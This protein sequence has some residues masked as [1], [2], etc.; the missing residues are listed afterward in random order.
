MGDM[1]NMEEEEAPMK[2]LSLKGPNLEEDIKKMAFESLKRGDTTE[3]VSKL[4]SLLLKER[5]TYSASSQ[6]MSQAGLLVDWLE[7][8]DPTVIST[9]PELQQQLVFG[10]IIR[11][12]AGTN[13]GTVQEPAQSSRPYLL[14]LLTHQASWTV[15]SST[16]SSLLTSYQPELEPSAVL[17]FLA[18][19]IHIPRLW[20]GRDQRPPKHDKPPD[21]LG[22]ES[23]MLQSLTEYVI[24]EA[25]ER[26]EKSEDVV[27]ERME[28]VLRCMSDPDKVSI[29]TSHLL[30][31]SSE[32]SGKKAEAGKIML[33][34]V[35]MKIPGCFTAR[36]GFPNLTPSSTL[37]A[38]LSMSGGNES[39]VDCYTHTLLSALSATST[40]K[41]WTIK[42]QEFELCARK[43]MSSHPI[44]F[45]RNLPLLASSLHGRT[46]FEFPIFRSR[47]H[48]TL[49]TILLGLLELARPHIFLPR[50]SLSL[51]AALSCYVDMFQAYFQRRESFIGVID[52]WVQFL[53][54]WQVAGG[55]PGSKAA[56]FLRKHSGVLLRLHSAPGTCKIDSLKSLMSTVSLHGQTMDSKEQ[57]S[58]A[59]LP[60]YTPHDSMD[61]EISRLVSELA[62]YDSTDRLVA[63]LQEIT[64][65]SAPRP[66]ILIHFQEEL[67]YHLT[68]TSTQVRTQAYTLLLRHL[69]HRPDSWSALL[70][71]Y[72]SAL[73]CGEESVVDSALSHLPEFAVLGQENVGRLLSTVFKLGIFTNINT[74]QHITSAINML[75]MQAGNN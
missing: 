42:M 26:D 48:L 16:V 18:A 9:C 56:A 8:L 58:N 34:S 75:N 68:H 54:S 31:V 57:N 55:P 37:L 43:L 39:V 13:I 27:K 41:Q 19:C 3:L 6:A 67:V 24:A 36:Q 40:G 49:F 61:P 35:Y 21:V 63:V 60:N 44:L 59:S 45:L 51:E 72:M 71:G 4:S 22:L 66:S 52:R 5:E 28:L 30:K 23:E 47:N 46:H 2:V 1:E 73:E 70:P 74:T 53:S 14:S 20:Q 62:N 65:V 12:T 17:D 32:T 50:Y 15:L 7:L 29:V 11:K 64:T 69:K 38:S 33:L 10:R 25:V